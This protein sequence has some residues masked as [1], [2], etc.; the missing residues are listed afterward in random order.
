MAATLPY[1]AAPGSL[2]TCLEKIRTAATPE[3]VTADF[4]STKLQIKGGTG[5]ALIPYLKKIGFVAPDGSPTDLYKRFRNHASAG[6]AAATAVRT[7]YKA[8]ASVNEYYYDVGDKELLALI[9]QVTGAADGDKV[10]KLTLSTLK[11]LKAF[12]DFEAKEGAAAAATPEQAAAD[13]GEGGKTK[14]DGE[15]AGRST[16]LGL[17]LTYTINLNLP[18]TADQAVFNAIFRSLRENLLK[19]DE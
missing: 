8:L 15:G 2:K 14:A 17:N 12:A 1:L 19:S 10:A 7:G 6:A 16:G 11:T 13:T 3:R 18:A 4:I 5:R 9:N